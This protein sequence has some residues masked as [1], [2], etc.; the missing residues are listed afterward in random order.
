MR[1]RLQPS[2]R[3]R[4]GEMRPRSRCCTLAASATPKPR[5]SMLQMDASCSGAEAQNGPAW[6]TQPQHAGVWKHS[7]ADVERQLP[8]ACPLRLVC[9]TLTREGREREEGRCA[10]RSGVTAAALVPEKSSCISLHDRRRRRASRLAPRAG[11]ARVRRRRCGTSRA[12]AAAAPAAPPR[13]AAASGRRTPRALRASAVALAAPWM[14]GN[15]WHMRCAARWPSNGAAA[16]SPTRRRAGARRAR[17]ALPFR[18]SLLG[19]RLPPGRHPAQHRPAALL[20]RRASAPHPQPRP[21]SPRVR[22]LASP[23]LSHPPSR[24]LATRTRLVLSHSH[25]CT[26]ATPCLVAPSRARIHLALAACGAPSLAL[27]PTRA[28]L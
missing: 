27:A 16:R 9:P 19:V 7:I 8:C 21:L 10:P 23:L 4:R 18:V 26:H 12:R 11:V 2:E 24:L 15:I 20:A 3:E 25:T 28:R 14:Q 13:S 5:L 1:V 6:S 17:G 22:P